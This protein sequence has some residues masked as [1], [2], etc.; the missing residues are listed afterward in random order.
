MAAPSLGVRPVESVAKSGR[1]GRKKA[2]AKPCFVVLREGRP[3]SCTF[4]SRL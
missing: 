1:G 2:A 4:M 3:R